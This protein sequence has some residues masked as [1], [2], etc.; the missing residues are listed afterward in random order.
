MAVGNI[1]G[2]LKELFELLLSDKYFSLCQDDSR[3]PNKTAHDGGVCVRFA[4]ALLASLCCSRRSHQHLAGDEG[5][6]CLTNRVRQS[7]VR[8]VPTVLHP[9]SLMKRRPSS[10]TEFVMEDSFRSSFRAYQGK[11]ASSV[12]ADV[13]TKWLQ[14]QLELVAKRWGGEVAGDRQFL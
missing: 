1:D 4:S 5:K 12:D 13:K 3:R 7:S 10:W 9:S 8:F 2:A 6:T 14:N 11:K